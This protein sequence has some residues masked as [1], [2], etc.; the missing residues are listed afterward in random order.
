MADPLSTT[1]NLINLLDLCGKVL[2]YLRDVKDG[3]KDCT[4]L[5]VEISSTRGI[6]DTLRETVKDAETAPQDKWSATIRSLD[7]DGGP[8]KRLGE[9]L[10]SLHGELYKAASARGLTKVAKRLLWPFKKEDA[11]KIIKIIDRQKLLLILA[12]EN[13]H[14][15]LSKEIHSDTRIIRADMEAFKDNLDRL[16]WR[17]DD[18]DRRN[19][20]DWLTPINYGT[21]Q[22]DFIS[23]R[24][25]GTGKWLLNSDK[26]Q[27]WLNTSNQTLFCPGIPGAGK[28]I[29]TSII[30]NNL[31][32]KFQN[33]A[34]VGIAYV[35]CNFRRQQEQK[36]S[37]LLASLLKQLIQ[38]QPIPERIKILYERHK[39]KRTR[40]SVDEISKVLHS[41]VA[42]YSRAF[43]VID[44]L[45]E[46]Q[47]SD[48]SRKRF[49]TELFDL[50]AKT[51]ANFLAT[52]R[53]IQETVKEF[54]GRSTQLEIR[55]S[56]DDLQKY[57]DG[58]MLRL[59][60]FVSRNADLQKE[61][62]NAII[63]AV[64]GMYVF[65]ATQVEAG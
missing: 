26:F 61:V 27:A 38:E 40:P 63:N 23:R 58:H 3:P 33:D 56:G 22:S 9:A 52:S 21:Q 60:S 45:D 48:G 46:C 59:P 53:F 32:A 62:K 43:I 44:A 6:L 36:P 55:A 17:Q 11:E 28:T 8:L 20:L 19:I 14:V 39:D 5:M 18:H 29:I 50:Q 35:Y 47:V 41:I 49:L 24:H 15:A 7:K 65:H 57:L 1:A 2:K 4:R 16:K 42:D 25:E 37:D 30:V 31:Y 64:D 10:T 12:L 34:S 13:D 51:G 54:E